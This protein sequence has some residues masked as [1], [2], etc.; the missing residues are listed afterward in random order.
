MYNI[1]LFILFLCSCNAFVDTAWELK[2]L[3]QYTSGAYFRIKID[4]NYVNTGILAVVSLDGQVSGLA[5][6][7]LV[8]YDF[9][10]DDSDGNWDVFYPGTT[11]THDGQVFTVLYKANA[12]SDA[13]QLSPA[14]YVFKDNDNGVYEYESVSTCN[15]VTTNTGFYS[16]HANPLTQEECQTYY[17]DNKANF[18]KCTIDSVHCPDDIPIY[19]HASA[20]D[21]PRGC[22]VIVNDGS[23]YEMYYNFLS[24]DEFE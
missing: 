23:V 11:G 16:G 6:E 20:W 5:D 24:M 10:R 21:K 2:P 22:L 9:Q 3:D 18:G 15:I 7:T 13:I 4:N 12:D 14:Y 8:H 1:L 17:E 19:P